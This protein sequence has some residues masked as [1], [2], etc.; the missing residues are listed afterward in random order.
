[1]LLFLIYIIYCLYPNLGAISVEIL[2]VKG[3]DVND[4][5]GLRI[6]TLGLVWRMVRPAEW[7]DRTGYLTELNYLLILLS[8]FCESVEIN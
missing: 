6:R 5:L 7:L 4:I 2:S 3:G 1:M 8:I